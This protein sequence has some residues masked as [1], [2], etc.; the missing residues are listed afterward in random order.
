MKP[1]ISE[2]MRAFY[3]TYA[4][5]KTVGTSLR[6]LVDFTLYILQTLHSPPT[7]PLR[8]TVVQILR[9]LQTQICS[10]V[11][12]PTGVQGVNRTPGPGI[13]A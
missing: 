5:H 2:K 7:D 8:R 11:F 9:A 10:L 4:M 1:V 13:R 6:I 12:N 3:L